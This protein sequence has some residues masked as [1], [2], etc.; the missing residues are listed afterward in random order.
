[1]KPD[2]SR[3]IVTVKMTILVVFLVM[4]CSRAIS[5]TNTPTPLTPQ[6]ISTGTPI[7]ASATGSITA[8]M[9]WNATP[10]IITS[11]TSKAPTLTPQS[12]L[13]A[14][15]SKALLLELLHTNGDCRLPCLW[16]QTPGKTEITEMDAFFNRFGEIS[17][18]ND[19][20]VTINEDHG[21]YTNVISGLWQNNSGFFSVIGLSISYPRINDKNS[22][23][24]WSATASQRSG[25]GVDE[26]AKVAYGDLFFDKLL[27]NYMLTQILSDYGEPTQVLVDPY[28]DNP[29][30]P[31]DYIIPFHLIIYYEDQGFFI[32]YIS[33]RETVEDHYIGCP[34]KTGVILM[35][36][37]PIEGERTLA[38]MIGFG[39]I[40][41]SG[42]KSTKSVDEATNL[43]LGEFY[44]IFKEANNTNCLE[45][46][47]K[48][49]K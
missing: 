26:V 20:F 23:F 7:L 45:T 17:I 12:T 11:L 21:K 37:W 39:S 16:G 49:W 33:P 27:Q 46:P 32:E 25:E 29:I 41:I 40:G 2:N 30:Y 38:D 15:E 24:Q 31:P 22:A 43:T 8:E 34:W 3:K 6:N 18:N 14:V 35:K 9:P 5:D 1:M 10:T 28:R 19:F 42:L 47:I 44:Q 48:L 4:G 36:V 13:T